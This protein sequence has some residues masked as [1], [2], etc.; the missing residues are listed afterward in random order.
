[1]TFLYPKEDPVFDKYDVILPE[2]LIQKGFAYGVFA[3]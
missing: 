3:L 1:M 2:E